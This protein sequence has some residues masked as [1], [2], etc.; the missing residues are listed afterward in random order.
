MEE[1][2]ILLKKK[3]LQDTVQQFVL[4]DPLSC[5]SCDNATIGHDPFWKTKTWK[6]AVLF[7]KQQIFENPVQDIAF[8]AFET[9]Q[10]LQ[11][12]RKAVI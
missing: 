11:Q 9:C 12:F 10:S 6:R 3:I 2:Y 1:I 8:E 7:W 5:F 4:E